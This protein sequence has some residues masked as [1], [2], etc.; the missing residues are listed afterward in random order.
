ML[1]VSA[2]VFAALY[3]MHHSSHAAWFDSAGGCEVVSRGS[4]PVERQSQ[5]LK[6]G[7]G[8]DG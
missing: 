8:R 1:C 4:V 6:G 5:A 3:C 2:H 7:G